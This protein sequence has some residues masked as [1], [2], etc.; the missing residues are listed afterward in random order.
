MPT[1]KDAANSTKNYEELQELPRTTN[2]YQQ[3]PRTTNNYQQLQELPRT[4]NYILHEKNYKYILNV[5]EKHIIINL[6]IENLLGNCV[7]TRSSTEETRLGRK[8][9]TLYMAFIIVMNEGIYKRW[10]SA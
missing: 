10:K 7:R 5:N 1:T 4:K 2:N 6:P 3:L 9:N 8:L